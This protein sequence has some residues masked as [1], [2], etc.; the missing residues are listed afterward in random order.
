MDIRNDPENEEMDDVGSDGNDEGVNVYVDDQKSD[1]NEQ[2]DEEVEASEES[3]NRADLDKNIM[4]DNDNEDMQSNAVE[5]DC[6]D[7]EFN[8]SDDD[9]IS[10]LNSFTEMKPFNIEEDL[11]PITK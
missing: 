6:S 5:S 7:N 8:A 1:F 4:D 3:G 9:E 2:K 11:C 10:E